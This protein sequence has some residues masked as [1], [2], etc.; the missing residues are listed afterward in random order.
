ML[1]NIPALSWRLRALLDTLLITLS[2]QHFVLALAVMQSNPL[3]IMGLECVKSVKGYCT[4]PIARS[5]HRF[6][7]R[8]WCDE[9][10]LW[11]VS[12]ST[13]SE[14]LQPVKIKP[15]PRYRRW[16]YCARLGQPKRT[17]LATFSTPQCRPATKLPVSPD[18]GAQCR[19]LPRN[20]LARSP[21]L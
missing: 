5:T 10:L 19:S 14:E 4:S 8:I 1:S 12:P 13:S 6:A 17:T 3:V 11:A 9:L 15:V 21:C 2:F 7:L 20:H 16:C 18:D